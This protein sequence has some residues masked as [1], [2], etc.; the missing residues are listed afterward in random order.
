[1]GE[2]V[3]RRLMQYS[4]SQNGDI[5]VHFVNGGQGLWSQLRGLSWAA[6]ERVFNGGL[7]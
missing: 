3:K 6:V 5:V 2:A 1:M 7:E 4:H